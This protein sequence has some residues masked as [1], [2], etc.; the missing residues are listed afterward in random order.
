MIKI[1]LEASGYD[2]VTAVNGNEALE[3]VVSEKPAAVLLDI[4]MPG[5]D[6]ITV[7]KKIRKIDKNLP[8]FIITSFSSEERFKMA[9]TFGASG[10]IVK[11]VDLKKE[12][13][14][15][16]AALNISDKYKAK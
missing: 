9:N 15:I 7:L 6:G 5:I 1:R 14:N 2:V 13:D 11:T 10:F 4:L 8:V 12:I 3:R 16:T